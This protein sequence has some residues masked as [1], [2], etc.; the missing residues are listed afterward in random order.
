M[1]TLLVRALRE[2]LRSEREP[3][4]H[5]EALA[6]PPHSEAEARELGREHRAAAVLWGEAVVFRGQAEVQTTVT[7]VD[8][9]VAEQV[10]LGVAPLQAATRASDALTVREAKAEELARRTADVVALTWLA[11]GEAQQALA[12][13]DGLPHPDART[14]ALKALLFENTGHAKESVI[15]VVR[16]G[17]ALAPDDAALHHRLAGL[18]AASDPKAALEEARRAV[19]LDSRRAAYHRTVAEL[20][21]QLGDPDAGA[22]EARLAVPT[23]P[24]ELHRT[25]LARFA[26]RGAKVAEQSRAALPVF[27]QLQRDLAAEPFFTAARPDADAAPVL[28]R[29]I[30]WESDL[31][32]HTPPIPDKLG[33]PSALLTQLRAWD[34]GWPEHAADVDLTGVDFSLLEKLHG[35]GRW[36]VTIDSPLARLDGIY[37]PTVS[38]PN[39]SGL[40]NLCKLRLLQGL[41]QGQPEAAARDVEHVAWLIYRTE[42]LIGAMVAANVLGQ[43]QRV[44]AVW[45]AAGHPGWAA[46]SEEHVKAL[47][48]VFWGGFGFIDPQVPP[49]VAR[50]ALAVSQGVGR[51]SALGELYGMTTI[52]R[53]VND[54][55]FAGYHRLA[56]EVMAQPGACGMV[57]QRWM[58]SKR[59]LPLDR[60]MLEK[61]DFGAHKNADLLDSGADDLAKAY[62]LLLQVDRSPFEAVLSPE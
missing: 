2:G 35:Y 21:T 55:D 23:N 41:K 11:R 52:L 36:D 39:F 7:A 13:L 48:R 27:L 29:L 38:I 22:A 19:A 46:M 40:G 58:A 31:L 1:H 32:N 47:R 15:D 53:S 20:L 10:E 62:L 24:E 45:V 3:R 28:N 26:A 8:P 4:F 51:C 6:A 57:M 56:D 50:E 34:K 44:R 12:T 5:L 37:F 43:V 30:G 59:E 61:L 9:A 42:T 14:F 25:L 60:L 17:L 33:L 16:S 49:E 18:L 54:P